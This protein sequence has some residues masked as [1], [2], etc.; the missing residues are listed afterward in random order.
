MDE[1]QISS[2]VIAVCIKIHKGVGPGLLESIYEELVCYELSKCKLK[3][4]RQQEIPLY[5][6]GRKLCTAFRADVIVEN[7]VLLELK[8]VDGLA[9]VHSKIVLSYLRLTGL[10]LGLLI[11]FRTEL[12]KNGITR[13]VNGL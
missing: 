1:N 9:P 5:Y 11:N 8:S 10:K 12:L 6:D 7:K 4:T 13:L 3:Y 2:R